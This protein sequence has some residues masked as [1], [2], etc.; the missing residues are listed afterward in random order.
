MADP[1]PD[2]GGDGGDAVSRS[3]AALCAGVS[4]SVSRT[5]ERVAEVLRQQA[6]VSAAV[7]A[8][9][10]DLA[11]TESEALGELRNVLDLLPHYAARAQQCARDMRALEAR[12][13]KAK[14]R[15][16]KLQR[17]GQMQQRRSSA[18]GGAGSAEAP[19]Q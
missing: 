15:A 10:G 2:V 18:R 12:V 7:S 16:H 6:T 17:K 13:R 8:A 19:K 4:R 1:P 11:W 5:N 14:Q 9:A 3:A